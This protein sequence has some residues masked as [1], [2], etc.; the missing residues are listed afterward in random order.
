MGRVDRIF[1]E[2]RS[3]RRK[4]L[5]PFI[6]AGYPSE[7]ATEA[8]IPAL[9]DAGASVIE[10]GIPFSDPIADGPVIAGAMH[11]AL[12]RGVT[13]GRVFEIVRAARDKTDA[14]L[15]AMVS[16]TIAH[17][18]G[19]ERFIGRATEAGFDGFIFPDVPAEESDELVGLAE[20]RDASISMLV[21]PTTAGARLA[22]VVSRCRGFVYLMAR[23]GITGTAT[24]L[25][26][27]G[28]GERVGAIRA[29]TDLPIACGFGISTPE[30]VR[31]VSRHAD[32]A[33]VG[34]ALVRRMGQAKDPVAE[35]SSFVRELAGGLV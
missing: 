26:A 22:E 23:V 35:A 11:E 4:A 21:A 28:L 34:S 1:R 7:Q 18:M 33:I 5:M 3:S 10:I 30:Q 27:D 29:L 16:Y 19:V 32:A 31:A 20:S 24:E 15:I 6:C 25:R 9:A 13:P 17:R 8:A 12:G 14:G 2:L